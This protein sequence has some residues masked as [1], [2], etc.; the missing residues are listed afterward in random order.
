MLVASPAFTRHII[1]IDSGE[2]LLKPDSPSVFVLRE[3]A[4]PVAAK[5]QLA[6]GAE[7]Y[8]GWECNSTP[9]ELLRREF[10]SRSHWILLMSTGIAVRVLDGLMENKHADPAVVVLDEGCHHAISLLSGHEGGANRLAFAVANAVG[11]TPVI[12]TATESLK[13]LVVG[14]G[15]RKNVSADAIHNALQQALG[16]RS[17]AEVRCM[18][19]IDLKANEP[20]LVEFCHI[21]DIPLR[22][23]PREAVAER[24]WVTSPSEWVEKNVGV[25]G[26]CEPCALMVNSRGRLIVPKTALNGVAVAIVDDSVN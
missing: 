10:R 13:P 24:D 16:E 21:N 7:I 2:Q 4:M 18:A 23:F 5:L 25:A 19:T 3:S 8:K 15:C 1:H 20:G 14:I 17:L 6:L 26:V 9:A 22:V 12:S 11:A